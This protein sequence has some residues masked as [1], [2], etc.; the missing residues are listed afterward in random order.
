MV[1]AVSSFS[2]KKKIYYYDTD[3]GG[4]VYYAN[5][6]KVLEEARTELCLSRGVDTAAWFQKGF[7]FVVVHISV[8]YKAPAQYGDIIE[9]T[10]RVEKVGNSSIHFAQEILKDNTLLV[11]AAV[12][13][14]CID[15]KS[16]KVQPV[17]DEIRKALAG[18][19]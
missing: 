6:L 16:F 4:V 5:Y 10:A 2:V 8:D 9:A 11:K 13:W 19:A 17:P 1:S 12:I 15:T 3:A 7:A 14:A 18:G